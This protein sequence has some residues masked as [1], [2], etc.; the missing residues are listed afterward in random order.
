MC[1]RFASL[2]LRRNLSLSL[3]PA[4]LVSHPPICYGV[5]FVSISYVGYVISRPVTRD[6]RNLLVKSVGFS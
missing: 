3:F 2:S 1:K 6:E 4:D 5:H